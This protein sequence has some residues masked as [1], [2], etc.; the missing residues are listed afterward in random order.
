MIHRGESDGEDQKLDS[1]GRRGLAVALP[2]GF[3]V[4]EV[5]LAYRQ[6]GDLIELAAIEP[7]V[8]AELRTSE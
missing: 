7:P 8:Y 4:E 6:D 2:E 1:D 3:A 5:V